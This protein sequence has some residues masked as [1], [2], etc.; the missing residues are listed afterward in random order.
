[1]STT[2]CHHAWLGILL[3]LTAGTT[4]VVQLHLLQLTLRPKSECITGI[5]PKYTCVGSIYN[6]FYS[7][8]YLWW[9]SFRTG[10]HKH[11][12]ERNYESIIKPFTTP[13]IHLDTRNNVET[14]LGKTT[15]VLF[16]WHEKGYSTLQ[17]AGCRLILRY[18]FKFILIVLMLFVLFL[19]ICCYY[20][21]IL[22][23][24]GSTH[25]GSA[26]L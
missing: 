25:L 9:E 18:F 13:V 8:I 11:Y 21:Q 19:L 15:K 20:L 16:I 6:A 17:S 2:V 3:F 4:S 7:F 26:P 14:H 10:I 5:T 22:S 1:M 24:P 23:L 12:T